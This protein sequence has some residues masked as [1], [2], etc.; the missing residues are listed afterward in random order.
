MKTFGFPRMLFEKNEKRDFLPSFFNELGKLNIIINLETG[1]GEKLDLSSKDYLRSNPKI[2][3]V[4]RKQAFASDVVTIIRT[5][6]NIELTQMKKGST[7]FSMIHFVTHKNRCE[8]L[9]SNGVNMIAM[10]SV[11]DDFG[12]RMIEYMKGTAQ[13]GMKLAI[14]LYLK[15]NPQKKEINILILGSGLVGKTTADIAIHSTGKPVICK[16]IGRNT[17]SDLEILKNL[18]QNTDILVDATYR[19]DTTSFI[20]PNK[21]IGCLPEKSIILDLTADD[22]D[23]KTNPIQVKAIEG[24]PTGNLDKFVFY[25]DDDAYN[26]I[27]DSVN[28]ENRR[29]TL[30][31][32]SWPAVDPVECLNIY[33]KQ[34]LP[35]MKVLA[36]KSYDQI[37]PQSEDFY[38]R[39][40]GKGSY[41]HF[42][43]Q[44]LLS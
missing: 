19:V 21:I 26:E 37:S 11:V 15:N 32:Y 3:F 14:E 40:L 33:Q 27:P 13:N 30:S 5:P 1:Y 7:L 9:K 41:H 31:C 35:F 20:I 16:M 29:L 4:S 38:S 34:L 28:A 10:D 18:I 12:R 8:F 25:P 6:K 42:I 22:Y 23:S 2:E 43:K 17:T 36:E 24:I 44:V 39:S